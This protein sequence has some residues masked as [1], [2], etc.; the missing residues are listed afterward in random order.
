MKTI[1][2]WIH[3]ICCVGW[4]IFW[5]LM[6]A[7][8]ALVFHDDVII[9]SIALLI[10]C[11]TGIYLFVFESNRHLKELV[12]IRTDNKILQAKL[13]KLK[14]QKELSSQ[15]TETTET[16]NPARRHEQLADYLIPVIKLMKNGRSH[17]DAFKQISKELGVR[18][19][20]VNAQCTRNLGIQT[21]EF[22]SLVNRN[23][24]KSL[25]IRKFPNKTNL[26]EREL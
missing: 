3:F 26:I 4:I 18:Y 23:E 9:A 8:G 5:L 24:I 11:G 2:S 13:K 14:L 15:Q 1:M 22:T 20:T 12:K 25:L 16:E 17:N 21:D 7:K 10:S 19:Q 6:V